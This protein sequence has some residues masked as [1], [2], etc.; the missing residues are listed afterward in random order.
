MERVRFLRAGLVT[1]FSGGPGIVPSGTTT[2]AR[3][4]P[5]KRDRMMRV[6]PASTPSREARPGL[7]WSVRSLWQAP[8]WSAG[9]RAAP[10]IGPLPRPK[11]LQVATSDGAARTL[12]GCAFRRS[13][14]LGFLRGMANF[15]G[16]AVSKTR[17]R[18]RR[19][20]TSLFLPRTECGG[21]GPCEAWWRGRT[22]NDDCETA[23]SQPQA[24]PTARSLSSGRPLR[25]G[26]VGAVPSPLSRGGMIGASGK[27]DACCELAKAT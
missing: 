5:L 21:G 14:S 13:A 17:A 25:A 20:D 22:D 2:G 18:T 1:P 6:T 16:V 4:A 15:D 9:R 7:S 12:V 19:E 27:G 3:G 23:R 26:P 8:R 11:R 24:P 10:D